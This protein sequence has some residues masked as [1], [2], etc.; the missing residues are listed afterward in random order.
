VEARILQ[1]DKLLQLVEACIQD[2]KVIAPVDEIGYAVVCSADE[3]YLGENR[4]TRSPKEYVFPQ[5]EVLLQYELC[6]GTATVLPHAPS[7]VDRVL[8][9]VRPC[10]A[11]ALPILDRVFGWGD[12]DSLYFA[13]RERTAVVS[14]AC[15][16]PCGACFCTS[17]GGSPAGIEGSDL[18]LTL[19]RDS[20]HVQIITERG[21]EL[22][23][24]YEEVFEES[25]QRRNR[26]RAAVEDEARERVVEL[27][28]LQGLDERIDFDSPV[29]ETLTPE[30]VDCGI[31]TFLCPT[32][33]CFDIQD[34][35]NPDRGERVRL[36]DACTF[37]EYTKTHAEQPRPTHARRYRQRIMHKF[38]Y[39]PQNF[40]KVLC[41]GCGRCIQYCPVSI[42]LRRVLKT[43]GA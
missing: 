11:V 18:L 10:D 37:F 40:G 4:P 24:Q 16:H 12:A 30:C 38:Q 17:L 19:L 35:G 14:I 36:W 33:H 6:G 28:D 22:V 41:V 3:M 23:E 31:C 8:F 39:Y 1:Q 25:D 21:Q 15:R 26:E 5:R 27:V 9:G 34:E 7:T 43:V 2:Y 29:W 32:C 42:D 20:Y 13:R